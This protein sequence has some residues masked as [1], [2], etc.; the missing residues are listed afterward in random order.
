MCNCLKFLSAPVK[1]HQIPHVSFKVTSQF[2]FKLWIILANFKLIQFLLWIEVSHQSPNFV[3]F[4]CCGENLPNS[5]MPNSHVIFQT[6]SNFFFKLCTFLQ[7][8]GRYILCTF[9]AQTLYTLVTR[10]EL[11]CKLLRFSSARVKIYQIPHVNFETISQFLFT[12]SIILQC[13]YT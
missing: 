8:L 1:L 6:T 7:C 10:S 5:F 11:L 9:I 2:D 13:H 3:T 4:E 12:F